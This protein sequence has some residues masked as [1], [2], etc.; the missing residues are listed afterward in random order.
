MIF[1]YFILFVAAYFVYRHFTW[2]ALPWPN[3]AVI[4]PKY[5][6]H[7]GYWKAGAPENTLLSFSEAA[8][9]GFSMVEMDVRN[10][11]DNIPVVFHDGTLK[12]M[13]NLD[14][15]VN[16]C[17]TAE[18][19]TWGNI[20]TL[21]EVLASTSIPEYLNIEL[22]T[23]SVWEGILEQKVSS[24]IKKYKAEQRV[25]FSSFNPLSLRRMSHLLPEVP[26]ALLASK[27]RAPDNNLYLRHMWFAPYVKL[28]ALH[29]DHNYV[30]IED[31]QKWKKRKVPVALWTVNDRAKAEAF[32]QAGA[33]SI[34]TD[35]LI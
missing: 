15:A 7:R 13:L 10:S 17:T 35:T 5:Q 1:I 8:K 6:G 31:L 4:P 14:K 11:K 26:R 33:F 21:E 28:H 32:L 12:R 3:G 2:K 22:K 25:L 9:R 20:P 34:I 16:E 27:E 18:L 30:S 24:L 29:L 19:K 23:S